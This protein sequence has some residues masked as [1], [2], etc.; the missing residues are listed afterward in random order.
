MRDGKPVFVYPTVALINNHPE[1]NVFHM[2]TPL[3]AT[4]IN[5]IRCDDPDKVVSN[6]TKEI[7]TNMFV[8]AFG[9]T[10]AD[11]NTKL[12]RR[13]IGTA[14]AEKLT[15]HTNAHIQ[16]LVRKSSKGKQFEYRNEMIF[17]YG[18]DSETFGSN[19]IRTTAITSET[20][21]V[22]IVLG[23]YAVDGNSPSPL[24]ASEHNEIV[25]AIYGPDNIQ[26]G[27]ISLE[28]IQALHD[29]LL[30]PKLTSNIEN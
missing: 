13:T 28:T 23:L 5:T 22:K 21:A 11:N 4:F 18:G 19:P 7:N 2:T 29:S 27:I 25:S 12:L 26:H 1:S 10:N 20:S 17:K 30:G 3:G 6:G 15:S 9:V 14:I 8:F 16:P 24:Q